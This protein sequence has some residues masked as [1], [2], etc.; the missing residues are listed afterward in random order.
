MSALTE[1]NVADVAAFRQIQFD[2]QHKNS[3]GQK[4]FRR[5]PWDYVEYYVKGRSTPS[6]TLGGWEP[7]DMTPLNQIVSSGALSGNN[8]SKHATSIAFRDEGSMSTKVGVGGDVG[9]PRG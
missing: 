5:I 7:V 3:D 6:K 1:G 2:D 9:W 4:V 8:T